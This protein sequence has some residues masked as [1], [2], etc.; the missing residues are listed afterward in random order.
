MTQDLREWLSLL[1]RNPQLRTGGL[2]LRIV[3][4][5]QFCD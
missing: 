5:K 3:V 4:T 2:K 1:L